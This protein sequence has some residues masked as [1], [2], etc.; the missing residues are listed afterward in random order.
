MTHTKTWY[1]ARCLFRI[2]IERSNSPSLIED[3]IIL[4]EASDPDEAIALAESEARE[5]AAFGW[6]D[7]NGRR[8]TP[9][10]LDVCDVYR[11]NAIPA[12]GVEVHSS[13]IRA[14]PGVSDDAIID[15]LLGSESES[16]VEGHAPF[17]PSL[18]ATA[19]SF[20]GTPSPGDKK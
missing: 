19:K 11:M 15:R 2:E 10:Y 16:H 4:V 17:V 12:H 7:E 13:R 3:R 18:E 1:G 14:E 8:V 20:R 6:A 9:R 5:Y